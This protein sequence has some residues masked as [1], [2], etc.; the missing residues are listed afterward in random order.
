MISPLHIPKGITMICIALFGSFCL[1]AQTVAKSTPGN[2][3]S[4][5]KN[6]PP[7]IKP[8]SIGDVVPEILFENVLNYKSKKAK[9]SDFRGKLVILDMWSTW[10]SS[11]IEAFPKM[12]EIQDK[13]KDRIQ[14]L[15]VNPYDSKY[16]SDVKIA[17]VLRRLKE[18]TGFYPTLPIPVHD[19]ILNQ[20]FPHQS[21]PHLILIEPQGTLIGITYKAE[22]TEE[23]IKAI[24][25]GKK[26]HIP[27][28]N[29]WAFDKETPLFVNGNGGDGSDFMY[30][31]IFTPYKEGIGGYIGRTIEDN[32]KVSRLYVTNYPLLSL[33]R[34]AYGKVLDFPLNRILIDVKNPS[35]FQITDETRASHANTY[36]YEVIAPPV[37]SEE[38][39]KYM[40]DDLFRNFHAVAKRETRTVECYQLVTNDQIERS[41][42]NKQIAGTD[43]QRNSLKKYMHNE[44]VARLIGLLNSIFPK[45][46]LDE[47]KLTKNISIDFPVEIYDYDLNKWKEFLSKNGFVLVEAKRKLEVAVITDK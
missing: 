41:I 25:S 42:S 36:C 31:S 44:P 1:A 18:R 3:S 27:V 34:I 19:T 9:L 14:I 21:V 5:F 8:L 12:Q 15:L 35:M 37:S 10:C 43:I 20:Y 16:D 13:F 28:K 24:L 40:Q 33:F 46:I 2:A 17:K 30:R 29:D 38:M 7:E 45:P 32:G 47:T 39:D 6:T 22:I 11:C 23:N 4:A 26:I